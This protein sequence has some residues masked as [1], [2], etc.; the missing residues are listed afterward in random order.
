MLSMQLGASGFPL[1][2]R[3]AVAGGVVDVP[4]VVVAV[5]VTATVVVVVAVVVG[6]SVGWGQLLHKFLH[7]L[8]K[9][10]WVQNRRFD[11]TQNA[12]SRSQ[13]VTT[14]TGR[15]VFGSCVVVSIGFTNVVARAVV[16]VD[17]VVLR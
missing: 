12:G 8:E 5:D 7:T 17:V 11:A 14:V 10:D 6:G 2:N 16:V 15:V 9:T 13:P 4:V 3:G 1:H